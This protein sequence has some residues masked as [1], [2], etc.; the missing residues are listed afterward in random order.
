VIHDYYATAPRGAEDLLAAELTA[1][2]IEGP[3]PRTGGV[4]FAGSLSLGYRACLWS[5]TASRVLLRIAELP[6]GDAD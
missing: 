2:G 4:A 1:L 3:K 5:R 6:A